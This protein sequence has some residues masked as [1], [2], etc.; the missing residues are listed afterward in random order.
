MCTL[1]SAKTSAL[2]FIALLVTACGARTAEVTDASDQAEALLAA[3]TNVVGPSGL[4]GYVYHLGND[5]ALAS[6]PAAADITKQ[7]ARIAASKYATTF[8]CQ[9]TTSKFGVTLIGGDTTPTNTFVSSCATGPVVSDATA[10]GTTAIDFLGYVYFP[11]AGTYTL[12]LTAADDAAAIYLGGTGVPGSG[13]LISELNYVQSRSGAG[14]YQATQ[15]GWVRLEVFWYNQ[16]Y[17]NAGGAQLSFSISGASPVQVK[18]MVLPGQ[19]LANGSSGLRAEV[20]HRGSDQSEPVPPTATSITNELNYAR[21]H[22]PN[23][24]F[25][26]SAWS[27]P[28]INLNGSDRSTTQAFLGAHALGSA[29]H[30]TTALQ[31]TLIDFSGVLRVGAAGYYTLALSQAD[32]AAAVYVGGSGAMGSGTQVLMRNFNSGITTVPGGANPQSLW[33][34]SGD[35]PVEIFYYNQDYGTDWGGANLALSITGPG[36]VTL[37]T[38]GNAP[39]P[40]PS[41]TPTPTPIPA[42]TPTPVP[43]QAAAG[44]SLN[45]QEPTFNASLPIWPTA[46]SDA[47][48]QAQ[49]NAGAQLLNAIA[50]ATQSGQTSYT[51]P[52]G[53]YRISNNIVIANTRNFTLV[54]NGAEIIVEKE[55][56][57]F[58][59]LSN[60]NLTIQ[61]PLTLDGDPFGFTQGTI[62]GTDGQTYIDLQLMPGYPAPQGT[63]RMMFFSPA[64]VTLR[65][66]QDRPTS[67]TSMGNN[68]YRLNC[69]STTFNY[70]AT[71]THND[72]IKVGNLM[73]MDSAPAGGD[74]ARG[75]SGGFE[76]RNNVNVTMTDVNVY[77]SGLTWGFPEQGNDVFQRFH[78][79]RRPGT[80]RLGAGGWMAIVYEG[81]SFSLLDSELSYNLDDLTDIMGVMGFAYQQA[82][83]NSVYAAIADAQV[84][85]TVTFTDYASLQPAGQAKITA[86]G[87]VT[88]QGLIDGFHNELTQLNILQ[89]TEQALQLLT[90]DRP[91]TVS[92]FAI[93]EIE[94]M[95]PTAM[96]VRNSFLH[97]GLA[98]G[99]NIKGALA[100][101]VVNNVIERSA[102]RGVGV[103]YDPYWWEGG[104]PRHVVVSNNTVRSVPYVLFQNGAAI[105]VGAEETANSALGTPIH[106]VSITSNLIVDPQTAGINI[107]NAV[108]VQV[109]NNTIV[110]PVADKQETAWGN[111]RPYATPYV[112]TVDSVG[113]NTQISGNTA[114]QVNGTYVKGFIY[115]SGRTNGANIVQSNNVIQP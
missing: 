84:G 48:K 59:L 31:T 26:D 14:T 25:L 41:V 2:G 82:G 79:V 106:N 46:Y 3:N 90:F 54:G 58:R 87:G 104:I 55:I 19:P 99:I 57:H 51:I 27:T 66:F 71:V 93:V 97:D 18:G 20:Y 85:Q 83:N 11:A 44:A 38:S 50:A 29:A 32:D 115:Q 114:T 35:Y 68:V 73:L 89:H 103:N 56:T 107:G 109:T 6:P 110:N 96:T 49:R 15:A 72:V 98:A 7:M 34:A 61:G 65:H 1:N 92:G 52:T 70:Y 101:T 16:Y 86:I 76:M 63:G 113:P 8:V 74:A 102:Y 112:I 42:P 69:N 95:R 23:Y 24:A 75:D 4:T 28:S 13:T 39:T 5:T 21:S 111:V 108:G 94:E 62:V 36:A 30:D 33:L 45:I 47:D 78:G 10:L 37:L 105:D 12:Q 22:A 67:T 9:P 77:S 81:G 40:I 60:T 64:G 100:S 80:N 88:D 91:V 53:V 17:N 43:T